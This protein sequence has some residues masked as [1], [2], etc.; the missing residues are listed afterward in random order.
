MDQGFKDEVVIYGVLLDIDVEVVRH[1]PQDQGK[2]FAPQPKRWIV[3]QINGT[4]ARLGRLTRQGF[5]AQPGR[6][7]YKKRT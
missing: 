5:L 4:R 7:R 1:N 6:G 2:G 3:E